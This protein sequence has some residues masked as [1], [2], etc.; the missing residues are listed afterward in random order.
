MPVSNKMLHVRSQMA[1]P[2]ARTFH[3][4]HMTGVS[5]RE[6]WPKIKRDKGNVTT[7][8]DLIGASCALLKVFSKAVRWSVRSVRS[9]LP[10]C[11]VWFGDYLGLFHSWENVCSSRSLLKTF[12][13]HPSSIRPSI[14]TATAGILSGPCAFPAFMRPSASVST[15]AVKGFAGILDCGRVS[16][17]SAFGKKMRNP[18]VD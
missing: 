15:S 7:C 18:S 4:C 11:S 14:L 6:S 2:N 16:V 5:D 12:R 1:A 13:I 10:R 8:L 17:L 9:K 3:G